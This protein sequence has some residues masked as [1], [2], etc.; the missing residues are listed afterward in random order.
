M[1]RGIKIFSIILTMLVLC[2]PAPL[3]AKET[4]GLKVVSILDRKGQQVGL[5]KGSYALL[6]GVG[7]YVS[8]WPSLESVSYELEQVES[9][10]TKNGFKTVKVLNPTSQSLAEK[11]FKKLS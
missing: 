10:L 5:Y 8:G 1:K 2:E 6:I 9:V 7:E 3:F 4:R 11:G